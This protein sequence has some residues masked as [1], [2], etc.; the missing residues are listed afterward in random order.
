MGLIAFCCS[1]LPSPGADPIVLGLQSY[2]NAVAVIGITNRSFHQFDCAVMVERK[3]GGEWPK[4]L[5]PGTILP[6]NQVVHLSARQQTNMTIPVLVYAPP[7]PWRISAFCGRPPV[8]MSS[9]RFRLGILALKFRMRNL[10]R[11]LL[12]DN[13]RQIQAS[14]PEVEQWEK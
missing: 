7:Y 5:G 11:T 9:L 1:K 4:G 6:P 8:Q 12:G 3:I 13:A 2:T 10:A 14:T